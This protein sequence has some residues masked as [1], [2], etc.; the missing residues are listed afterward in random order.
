MDADRHRADTHLGQG[1]GALL[2]DGLWRGNSVTVGTLG[3]C[4]AL[5]V[6]TTLLNAVVMGACV[7]AVM[8]A[9]SA[10]VA[11]LRRWIPHRIRLIAQIVIIATLVVVVD[12]LL[13]AYWYPMRQ[14]L[15]PYVGLI[16]TN[17][18]IMGR[19]EAFAMHKPALP[20]AVDGV[21]HGL[22]YTLVLCAV[23]AVRELLGRGAI[24]GMPVLAEIGY[25][26]NHLMALAPGAFFT[27]GTLIALAGA[28]RR[29][30]TTSTRDATAPLNADAEGKEADRGH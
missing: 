27:L 9:A 18:V 12:L 26:P 19:T 29:R 23:A 20:A 6:T 22:G 10:V 15:G 3:I 16:I 28:I 24:V 11:L 7:T 17:C 5:A 1:H 2:A 4:S 25:E 13:E 30:R 8:V 21:A 14:R